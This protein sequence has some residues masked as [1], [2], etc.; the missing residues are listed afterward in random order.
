[1]LSRPDTRR[2]TGGRVN[3][4]ARNR[5]LLAAQVLFVAAAFWLGGR[6]LFRDWGEVRTTLANVR[7]SWSFA[8][9]STIPIVAGYGVLI[10]TWRV[11]LRVWGASLSRRHATTIYFISNLGRYIPGKFWQIAAMSGMAQRCGVSPIA[12]AGSSLVVNLVNI[13]TGFLVVLASGA[14]VLSVANGAGGS[15]TGTRVAVILAIALGAIVISLPWTLP[16]MVRTAARITGKTSTLQPVPPRAMWVAVIGTAIAWVLYGIGFQILARAVWGHAPGGT[17]EYV[18]AYT[19]S[20]LIGY[21]ALL[22]M[23]WLAKK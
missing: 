12:A 21:L 19:V 5:L 22:A 1:M 23:N 16:L 15:G 6:R 14:R 8:V 3:R 17:G 11:M 20:Y 2:F 13:A 4:L 7:V 9:A 10:E 18:A